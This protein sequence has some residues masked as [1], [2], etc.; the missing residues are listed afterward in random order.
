ETA[1]RRGYSLILNHHPCVFPKQKGLAKICSHGNSKLVFKAI[2]EGI[3]VVST[4]TNF[5]QCA[6]EVPE[7]VSKALGF[8]PLGRLFEGDE[9]VFLKLVVFVPTSHLENVRNAICSAGAGKIGRYDTCAFSLDGEGTFRGGDGS[10]PFLG[11]T[12]R[13]EK[14]RETR[15]ETVFPRGLKKKVLAADRKSAV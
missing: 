14:V 8:K 2:R 4:H 5:D 1:K 15:L 6:L 7:A 3:A 10:N 12:G 11:K 13:L 9:A